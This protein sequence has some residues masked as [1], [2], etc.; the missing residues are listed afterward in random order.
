MKER[1][2]NRVETGKSEHDIQRKDPGLPSAP[3]DP[4]MIPQT[5]KMDPENVIP[6]ILPKVGE[7]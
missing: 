2:I 5:E 3:S 4:K 7:A 6:V 1:P